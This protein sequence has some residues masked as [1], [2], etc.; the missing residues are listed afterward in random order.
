LREGVR[1]A[2]ATRRRQVA[3]A[4]LAAGVAVGTAACADNGDTTD[5]TGQITLVV[6]LFGEEGFG[7]T[8]LYEQYERD[9]P[10]IRI[11]ERGRG[12][13]LG[14]NNDRLVQQIVAGAGAGDVV[15]HFHGRK[16]ASRSAA[17]WSARSTNR[18]VWA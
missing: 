9:N 11:E 2:L 3:A 6:D 17:P 7:Y 8:A 14:D 5:D 12:L 16:L 18:S 10:H 4:L 13:G 1:L 15:A